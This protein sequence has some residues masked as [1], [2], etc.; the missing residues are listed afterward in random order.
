MLIGL[1]T[2]LVGAAV[3][4]AFVLGRRSGS[5]GGGSSGGAPLVTGERQGPPGAGASVE[6]MPDAQVTSMEVPGS[7]APPA[8]WVDV[9]RPGKVRE[10][11]A[12][13][14]WLKEQLGKPL[15]QGF[16][17][18]WAAFLGSTGEDLKGQFKGAV[19]D[20]VANQLLDAPFR[21]VWFAGDARASTPAFVV[22]KP[23][24]ASTSA[25]DALDGVAN[26]GGMTASSCPGG[27]AGTYEMKR[28]LVAEQTLW[29]GRTED[30]LVLARHPVAVLHGLCAELPELEAED[31]VDVE[32]GFDPDAYGRE[33]QLLT[34]VVGLASG[35]RLQFGVEG[36]RLVGRGIAGELMGGPTRLDAAPLSDDLLRLVPE[37]TPVLLAVQL[38]LPE[39]LSPDAL[40][41]F[42]MQGG[43]KGPTRTRQ[44]ALVW[45]PRGDAALPLEMAVLWGRAEDATALQQLFSGGYNRLVTGSFCNH[46]VM[47]SSDAELERLRKAC[48][49]K[50]P[51]LLNAAGPVVAG[52]R[53]PTSVA[54][55]VNTGRLLSGL[56]LDGFLSEHRVRR[57]A[58]MQSAV[59]PEI[60]AARRDLESLP[61]LGLRGTVQGDSL[62]PGGFGS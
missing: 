50:T 57:N 31:T 28:W 40:K 22:P 38:K 30:R 48:E 42:W 61:Y 26:R 49:G 39:S 25:F 45:T 55:G 2:V 44:V 13:N 54:F 34:H 46:V 32:L 53:A 36:G 23:G 10:A 43:G 15:G 8:I 17:G 20:L 4:G 18:G 59:P 33:V 16:V 58:P 24:R 52:L 29:A 21:V 9:H 41:E 1:V 62:V 3:A 6:G 5:P 51:N 35:T 47:A 60:E 12:G 14:A 7:A 27:A 11:L 56:T 37:E 19:L